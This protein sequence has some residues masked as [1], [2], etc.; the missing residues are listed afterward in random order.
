MRV[1]VRQ[2]RGVTVIQ[3]DVDR[4]DVG[5]VAQF[6]QGF[7]GLSQPLGSRV[8]LDL[9]R[10]RT[11]DSTGLGCLVGTFR[12]V[13]AAGGSLWLAGVR[14]QVSTLLRITELDRVM[15]VY[16][17]VADALAVWADP[18]EAAVG[19]ETGTYE[20]DGRSQGRGE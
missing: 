12:K 19:R 5:S 4:L 20:S 1:N 15:A 8:V 3:P 2:V 10:V 6:C 18:A 9:C 16:A 17:D 7:E 11:M 13:V 14:P